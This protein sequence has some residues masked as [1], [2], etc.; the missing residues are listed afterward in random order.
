MKL[1]Q[2]IGYYL[3]GFSIGLVILAFFLNGKKT[4][5]SYG[6]EARVLKN[7]NSKKIGY[8]QNFSTLL[9]NNEIDSTDIINIL[10]K[11]DINFS[12]SNPRQEPCGVYLIEGIHND[13]EVTL[14]IEN[15]DSTATLINLKI[16]K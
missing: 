6:P 4:S 2:R 16:F 8:S 11:G 7:I 14:T 3:G 5:C 15:C 9:T 13:D 12:E 1:I 10:Q